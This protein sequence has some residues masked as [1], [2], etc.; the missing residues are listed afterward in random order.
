MADE[1]LKGKE[2]KKRLQS[3][4]F[5]FYRTLQIYFHTNQNVCRPRLC[6][7]IRKKRKIPIQ[8]Q[9]PIIFVA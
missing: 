8:I 7:F 6:D 9:I 2:R 4:L 5:R 3:L 1:E